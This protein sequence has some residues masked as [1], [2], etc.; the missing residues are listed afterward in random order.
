M[1][2]SD[3]VMRSRNPGTQASP[4]PKRGLADLIM[5]GGLLAGLA[6]IGQRLML[7]LSAG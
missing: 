2:L 6:V 5:I 1:S 3:N 4:E 7:A